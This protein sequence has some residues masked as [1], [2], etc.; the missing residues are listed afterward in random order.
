MFDQFVIVPP[1]DKVE[2]IFVLLTDQ[3]MAPGVSWTHWKEVDVSFLEE[4]R[5]YIRPS[6]QRL[7]NR[8][9]TEHI[10]CPFLRQILRPHGY[11]IDASSDHWTLQMVDTGRLRIIPGRTI[12]WSSDPSDIPISP[13]T[14]PTETPIP[15]SG[16][17]TFW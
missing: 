16:P 17:Q 6:H 3:P 11:R 15:K 2:F 13:P 12:S 1:L 5:P 7:L 4:F 8:A 14:G 10:V 9:V